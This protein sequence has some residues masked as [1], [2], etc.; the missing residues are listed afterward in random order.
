MDIKSITFIEE[1]E[2]GFDSIVQV[3]RLWYERNVGHI[4]IEG[5]IFGI[6]PDNTTGNE[7][8]DNYLRT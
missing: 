2:A 1:A 3:A 8:K 4:V 5:G 7:D 6:I